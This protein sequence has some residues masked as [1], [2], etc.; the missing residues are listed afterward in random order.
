M[1]LFNLLPI[2]PL[3]GYRIIYDLFN[4][5]RKYLF[6][7]IV[8]YIGVLLLMLGIIIFFIFGYYAIILLFLYLIILNVYKLLE[9]KRKTISYQQLMLYD[10]KKYRL[11]SS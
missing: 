9:E 3:D 7:E 11:K 8:F 10:L 4:I 6:K 1:L 2:Y 5:D